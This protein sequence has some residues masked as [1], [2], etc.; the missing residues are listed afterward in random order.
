M[1][2]GSPAGRKVFYPVLFSQYNPTLIYGSPEHV[3]PVEQQ[4]VTPAHQIH[5]LTL[6]NIN[7][8]QEQW[9]YFLLQLLA[10]QILRGT[11]ALPLTSA[12]FF[13]SCR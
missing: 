7:L 3:P 6:E 11:L 2:S 10:P 1:S 12:L 8:R 13:L 4:L 5:P 9:P